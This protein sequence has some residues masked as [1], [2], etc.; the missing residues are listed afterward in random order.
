MIRKKKMGDSHKNLGMFLIE[1]M[2]KP[3]QKK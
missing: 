1:L 2:V 3:I